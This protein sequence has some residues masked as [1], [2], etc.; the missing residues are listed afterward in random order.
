[1]VNTFADVV[2]EKHQVSILDV[3]HMSIHGCI[4]CQYCYSHSGEC[5]Q[6]DDMAKVYEELNDADMVVFASPIY[7]LAGKTPKL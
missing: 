5:V 4:A 2:K 7:N 6:K 1:M 3:A